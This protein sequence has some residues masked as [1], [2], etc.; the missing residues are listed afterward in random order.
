MSLETD[1][2]ALLDSLAAGGIHAMYLPPD[3]APPYIVYR[4][5]SRE[6]ETTLDGSD[7]SINSVVAFHCIDQVYTD[8]VALAASVRTT[9]ESSALV[10]YLAGPY[11]L[12]ID[13]DIDG[14]VE[15]IVFGFWH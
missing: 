11:D 10:A 12:D 14:Y 3:Q 15:T 7:D 4:V 5:Q 13:F 1:L 9:I 8:A 6:S 2:V